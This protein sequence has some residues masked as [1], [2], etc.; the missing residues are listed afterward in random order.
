MINQISQ[1]GYEYGKEL[2]AKKEALQKRGKENTQEIAKADQ[3]AASLE[4]S[5]KGKSNNAYFKPDLVK[6][7]NMQAENQQKMLE[8][9]LGTAKDSFI[10]QAGGLKNILER[11]LQGQKTEGITVS[12]SAQ[13]ID[14]AKID[15]AEGGYWSAENTASRLVEFAKA[16]SGNN[17][18]QA[19]KMISAIQNGFKQ[20]E[21][22]WGG[23]L[24]EISQQTLR[25]TME[26][27]ENWKKEA[28]ES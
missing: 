20:A 8:K 2:S 12:V 24:P 22:L 16:L 5:V 13:D 7:R 11:A 18:E 1:A 25:L 4:V 21:E 28:M 6:I 15:V 10:R 23:K 19:D 14:Q 26:K 17:P 3:A 9:M 27:M